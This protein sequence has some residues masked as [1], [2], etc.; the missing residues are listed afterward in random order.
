MT[1]VRLSGA[2]L[3][4]AGVGDLVGSTSDS[5]FALVSSSA[6]AWLA[7]AAAALVYRRLARTAPRALPAAALAVLGVVASAGMVD[8]TLR[9]A[10]G[11]A[12]SIHSGWPAEPPGAALA[13][14]PLLAVAGAG[15][16]LA[17][18]AWATWR[19]GILPRAA[20]API[21]VVALLSA[22][23]TNPLAP[24]VAAAVP[25]GIA[26]LWTAGRGRWNGTGLPGAAG[27]GG[28]APGAGPNG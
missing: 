26:L 12:S 6:G 16:G 11:Y 27:A 19:A 9:I 21:A 7:L 22:L 14:L 13:P 2:S 24:Y 4:A 15:V 28:D 20:G 17:L 10:L 23:T 5:S 8:A 18:L 25:L 1:R 3:I